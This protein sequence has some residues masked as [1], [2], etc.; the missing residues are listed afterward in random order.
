[1]KV[2]ARL[3]TRDF[4]YR[5]RYKTVGSKYCGWIWQSVDVDFF[6]RILSQ[7]AVHHRGYFIIYTP[8]RDE[9]HR[10]LHP[11]WRSETLWTRG[12]S[13]FQANE[14]PRNSNCLRINGIGFTERALPRQCL[15]PTNVSVVYAHRLHG[16]H[17]KEEADLYTNLQFQ[18]CT[19]RR[20]EGIV[21]RMPRNL[22]LPFPRA[23]YGN[24][25]VGEP[26]MYATYGRLKGKGQSCTRRQCINPSFDSIQWFHGFKALRVERMNFASV[27]IYLLQEVGVTPMGCITLTR[28]VLQVEA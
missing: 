20:M 15:D 17:S 6:S 7:R 12:V 27:R 4:A 10:C 5:C 19:P 8:A 25:F 11:F 26:C 24:P 3:S 2:R 18:H 21:L 13:G 1:M 14:Q 23:D 28:A 16:V 22:S 9:P